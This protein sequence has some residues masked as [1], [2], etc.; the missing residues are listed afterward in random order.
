MHADINEPRGKEHALPESFF[1]RFEALLLPAISG[2]CLTAAW[3]LSLNDGVPRWLVFGL[4]AIAYIAGGWEMALDVFRGMLRFK[5]DIEF[6]MLV[7]GIGAAAIGHYAEGALL[8]FLF[9]LGHA[10]EHYAM[11]RARNAIRALGSI[12]PRT[13]LRVDDSGEHIVDVDEL[14]VGDHVRI[15]PNERIGVDGRIKDGHSSVDQSPITGESL[16]VAR[17]VNDSVF[18]GSLNG[19]GALLVQVHRLASDTTMARMIRLVEEARGKQGASQR[20]AQGF[21]RVFV[22]I[23]ILGTI[24]LIVIPP[25]LG[26]LTFSE[27]FLRGITVLVGASPCALAISTPSAV[28]A[29]VAQAARNGILIKGGKY[30]EALGAI[31]AVAMDKT[32]TITTGRPEL[33]QIIPIGAASETALLQLAG[34]LEVQSSHPLARAVT[35]AARARRL[36]F[37]RVDNLRVL[38]GVGIEAAIDGERFVI[39]GPRLL[40]DEIWR[41]AKGLE[42]A[43]AAVAQ[44][45]AQAQTTMVV[46]S[47]ENASVLGVLSLADRPRP[48]ARAMIQRLHQLGVGTVAMLTGD[49]PNVAKA[50]GDQVGVDCVHA[51]LMPEEKIEQVKLLLE[52][53]G[54]V[55]MVGDGVNDAP[56]LAVATVGIAMGAGGTDVALETAD[57]ALMA[58]DLSKLPFAIG[59]S[60]R[61]RRT[62]AQNFAIS[63]GVIAALVPFAALGIAPIWVAVLLHEGSTVVVVLNALRLLGHR[64]QD[65]GFDQAHD[66]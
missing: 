52:K 39:G 26:L 37:A 33:M 16:P 42:P 20:F 30:L 6:L 40:D 62:I 61:V 15:R 28:L 60:R 10:L 64:E 23:V 11:G 38:P 1:R 17:T 24:A 29:G 59:L 34:G 49:N 32:G 4:Y 44:A 7:A 22:P 63:L 3:V 65:V 31:G 14:A 8:F 9:A 66:K 45:E 36:E 48:G 12:A 50:I 53:H 58:D 56:A 47:V 18:A 5:F 13:A 51:S 27:S 21:T 19:D 54:T 41:A 55:A 2:T 57:V 43:R 25:L 35:R 46:L